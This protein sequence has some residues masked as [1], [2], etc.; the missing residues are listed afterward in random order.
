M[1]HLLVLYTIVFLILFKS[2]SVD[3]IVILTHNGNNCQLICLLGML[4]ELVCF[5][6]F[7]TMSA[8]GLMPLTRAEFQISAS[9]LMPWYNRLGLP[10]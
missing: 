6:M 10:R 8:C 4:L 2:F 1:L 7:G 3:P 9:R 5:V